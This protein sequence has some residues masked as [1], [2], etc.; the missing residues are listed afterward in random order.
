MNTLDAADARVVDVA[1]LELPQPFEPDTGALGDVLPPHFIRLQ[2][3]TGSFQEIDNHG[4][5]ISNILL[6]RQAVKL[7]H[8]ETHYR[9]RPLALVEMAKTSYEDGLEALAE[10]AR[11]L[12]DAQELS[13][14]KLAHLIKH[15][16]VSPKTVNNL[17]ARRNSVG[18]ETASAVAEGLGVETWMLFLPGMP[19]D[20]PTRRQLACLVR[21]YIK[22]SE[23]GRRNV[24][25]AA[26]VACKHEGIFD[27]VFA[28]DERGQADR[29]DTKS[30]PRKSQR[31]VG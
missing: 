11:S 21:A 24:M 28:K 3:G 20:E 10:N 1:A 6:D 18:V 4:P 25:N 7:C 14:A 31:K 22:V 5:S 19:P 9:R 12:K 23:G 15:R 27:D 17:L 29:D 26:E 2:Q 8:S 13:D 30:P 16:G